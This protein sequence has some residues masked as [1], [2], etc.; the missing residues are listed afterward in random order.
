E[1]PVDFAPRAQIEDAE[2]QLYELAETGRYDGGFQRFAQALTVA[3]DM[4]AKAFQRDGKLSGISTGLRDL[5]TKMGG[6]QPS[7]LIIVA[8]RPGMGKTSLATNIAY[9]IA[10]AY[11]GE[12]QAD[13]TIKAVHGGAVGFFSCEMS[14]EQLATRILAERTGIPSS[15]IRRGGITE[16]D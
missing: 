8:G 13:G 6:L 3:V 2:R 14:G 10:R 15:N 16:M 9:N 5:D 1:A 12:V 11:E 7:D 4:A